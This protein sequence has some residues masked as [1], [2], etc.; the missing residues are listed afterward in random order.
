VIF[1]VTIEKLSSENLFIGVS[2][3]SQ[4]REGLFCNL[5]SG[6]GLNVVNG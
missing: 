5:D 1:K 3:Q 4:L 6:W 2:F